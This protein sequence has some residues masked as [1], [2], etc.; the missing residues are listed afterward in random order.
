MHIEVTSEFIDREADVPAL[1][2]SATY[3]SQNKQRNCIRVHQMGRP[4][5]HISETPLFS[6][7]GMTSR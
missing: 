5:G 2:D 4:G 7:L 1:A 6:I 3:P